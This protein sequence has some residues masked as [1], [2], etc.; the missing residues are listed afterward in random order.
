LFE[1][2]IRH[3]E[4]ICLQEHFR[5]IEKSYVQVLKKKRLFFPSTS[6][7]GGFLFFTHQSNIAIKPIIE[8]RQTAVDMAKQGLFCYFCLEQPP[9]FFVLIFNLAQTFPDCYKK[10]FWLR[11]HAN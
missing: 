11:Q 4:A 2:D 9:D 1:L 7:S 8:N 5:R 6:L 10:K 3:T